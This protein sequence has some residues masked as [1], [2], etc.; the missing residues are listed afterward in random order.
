M[1]VHQGL[2]CT[3]QAANWFEKFNTVCAPQYEKLRDALQN[4]TAVVK[5]YET[6]SVRFCATSFESSGKEFFVQTS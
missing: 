3:L 5:I 1:C 2:F 4:D 6:T